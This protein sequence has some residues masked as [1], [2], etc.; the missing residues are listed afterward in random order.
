MPTYVVCPHIY[1]DKKITARFPDGN[2]PDG[3]LVA[4]MYDPA[5]TPE[6]PTPATPGTPH[7]MET[8]YVVKDHKIVGELGIIY[9]NR[10]E[11]DPIGTPGYYDQ[12]PRIIFQNLPFWWDNKKPWN[13]K[14]GWR[15]N[16]H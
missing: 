16:K 1:Q 5:S 15:Q 8:V 4:G 9:V 7:E 10:Q 2:T 14:K 3:A 6:A 12:R 11:D 13:N